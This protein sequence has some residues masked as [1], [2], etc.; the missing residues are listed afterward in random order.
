MTG[1]LP[2]P[3][4]R[5]L[6]RPPSLWR[7]LRQGIE[8]PASIVP[9]TIL[10]QP[11]LQLPGPG[12]PLVV[13]DPGLVRL[14]LNDRA[15]DFAREKFIHRLFRRSWGKGLAGA[16][17]EDWRRQRHAAAP[18][19]SPKAVRGY[20][21]R[22]AA[23]A[24]EIVATVA[25]GERLDLVRA[26]GRIIAR[27]VLS[28]LVEAPDWVD[29]DAA[30]AAI[31]PY[32][33]AIAR[34]GPIDLLPLPERVIDR[35]QGI[36][37]DPAVVWLRDIAARMTVERNQR[38][39]QND[40][41]ALIEAVGGPSRDNIQGLF[42]SA[43]DTT[44][45]GASWALHTLALRPEWQERLAE[46]SRAAGERPA[47][48]A[49]PLTRSA[50]NEVLRLYP[51]APMLSRAAAFDGELGGY[52]VRRG[53]AV[54]VS[55]YAMH[56]HRQ[57][58]DRPDAFEPDRFA[59]GGGNPDAFMPFGTGPRMCPAAQF[60]SAEIAV[61]VARVLARQRLVALEHQPLVSLRV[62][63]HSANGLVVR[64]EPR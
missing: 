34:F 58:W 5:M 14:V 43:M 35:L 13:A 10:D 46:E 62:T 28:I 20:L 61:I 7:M 60:A 6:E 22:F 19:F 12:A 24:D 40:M 56:R 55:I 33:D 23:C 8:D 25:P 32:V 52:R 50:V 48:E 3:R 39:P 51:P 42:P 38:R 4:Y 37:S 2:L 41:I 1:L 21:D 45:A 18:A 17:G 27:I 26:N 29:R 30:A 64:A 36:D 57:L 11:A 9:A 63:T 15:G 59:G 49:L 31:R 47:L 53:Q 44:V 54:L 16:E